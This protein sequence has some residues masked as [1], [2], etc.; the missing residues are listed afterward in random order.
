MGCYNVKRG[1]SHQVSE[2]VFVSFLTF[3]NIENYLH[4]NTYYIIAGG[5]GKGSTAVKEERTPIQD[6]ESFTG[7]DDISWVG[8]VDMSK[9]NWV[10]KGTRNGHSKNYLASY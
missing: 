4:K 8:V 2:R 1:R 5:S 10:Y 7:G 9:V 3:R 6:E